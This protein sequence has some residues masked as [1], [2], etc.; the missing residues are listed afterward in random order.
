MARTQYSLNSYVGGASPAALNAN[1]NNSTTTVV[2]S[3]TNTSWGTLGSTGG[4]FLALNYGTATEEKIWVPSGTYSWGSSPVILTNVSRAV[5]GTSAQTLNA[6]DPVVPILTATDLQEANI[7][8]TTILGSGHLTVTSGMA[9]LSTGSGVKYGH[10][11]SSGGGSVAS[12]S[13]PGL[14]A[15][16]GTLTQ[17]GG[18]NVQDNA[19]DGIFF[20]TSGFSGFSGSNQFSVV[21]TSGGIILSDTSDTGILIEETGDSTID[22]NGVGGIALQDDSANGTFIQE[23]GTGGININDSGGGGLG[24]ISNGVINISGTS[25]YLTLASGQGN[26]RMT[27]SPGSIFSS[28]S[29]TI[30]FNTHNGFGVTSNSTIGLSSSGTMALVSS[31]NIVISGSSL[32]FYPPIGSG[33]GGS[34]TAYASLS[35]IGVVSSPGLLT[36]SGGFFIQDTTASGINFNTKGKITAVSSGNMLIVSSG[37]I[38]FSGSSITFYP[39]VSVSGAVT[40]WNT[41][42]GAV[43]PLSGDYTGI[44]IA[45]VV[46]ITSQSATP[47][48]DT[49]NGNIF[50]I[51]GLAQAITSMTTNLTGTPVHGQQICIEFT[52]NGTGRGITWGSSFASTT[53]TLPTTTSAGVILRCW[54][55]WNVVN[56]TWDII[57]KA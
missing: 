17:S 53:V 33:G 10:V 38:T 21:T 57:S 14:T 7:L 41:R 52:D 15:S 3:G 43:V 45:N 13:G 26:F 31:G 11:S 23:V 9:I 47:A 48:I 49:D 4:F 56:S 22:I 44:Q 39:A 5:D 34:T 12:L 29:G 37:N 16:P 32:S 18:F 1:I 55:T 30:N 54:F 46:V 2:V 51:T 42:T 19:G 50:S 28:V 24:V 20:T 6:G 25:I 27:G 40:S 8:V 36:Q 35:G